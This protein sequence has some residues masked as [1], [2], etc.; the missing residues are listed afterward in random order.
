MMSP[1]EDINFHFVT[2]TYRQT[3]ENPSSHLL[4]KHFCISSFLLL[5]CINLHLLHFKI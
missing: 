2:K 5:E 3:A 1:W 4:V